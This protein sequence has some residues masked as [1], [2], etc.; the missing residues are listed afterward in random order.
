MKL[1]FYLIDV[2]YEV[3]N[4]APVIMLWGLSEDSEPIL[5]RDTTFRP[6]FYAV[7]RDGADLEE[8]RRGVKALSKPRSPITDVSV[9]DRK[10]YGRPV[11]ALKIVTVVPESVREYRE[12]VSRLPDVREVLEAD[13]RFSMRY[14]LDREA[15]PC[16]WYEAEVEE[17]GAGGL[18]VKGAYTLKSGLQRLEEARPPKLKTLAFDIEVYSPLGSLRPENNPVIIIATANSEGEVRVMV[19]EEGGSD[20]SLIE[21]FV[22]YVIDY[23]PD[24]VVGYNSNMFDWQYLIQRAQALKVRLDVGRVKGGVPRQSAYGHISIP[25]RLH[26]DLYNFAE[27]IPEVKVKSLDEVADYLGVM[28][29]SERVLIPWHEIPRY[30][31]SKELRDTLIRYARDDA[32]ST[33]LLAKEFLPFAIQLSS[34]TGLPLDQV[35]AASVGYRLEWYLMR[36][37]VKYGEL[38]PN[39]VERPYEPYKG[40]IVLEP[41]KGVHEDVVVLDFTSMYPN[42]MI[43]YNVSPDT[44][45][46]GGCDE[47]R[48]HTIEEL[49]Y[50]FLKEPPGFYK[51]VLTTLLRLR[52]EIRTTMKRLDPESLEYRVLDERQRVL[53]ILANASYGYM[54]WVG[55]RW[56]FKEG[57]ESITALGRKT[58]LR[59]IEIARSLGL[60]V[61]YGDTD[62]LFTSYVRDL[63]EDFINRVGDEL[64]LEIKVDKIYRRVFFTEAKKRY[65]GLTEDGRI[66]IVGFEAVRGD[67]TDIAKDVQEEVARIVLTTKNVGEAVNHVRRV[68]EEVRNGRVG[69]EK[70]IIWKTLTKRVSEYEVDAPHVMAARRL[71]KLGIRTDV[72]SKIGYV[73]VRG[74]GNI[75]SRAYP[76]MLVKPNEIDVDYYINHQVIPAA[77]R[78]LSY[79]GVTEKQLEAPRGRSLA[80]FLSKK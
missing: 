34:L 9:A 13:I 52:S 7:P 10:Y 33:L 69:I 58:I 75:S 31:D 67:W 30:W 2:S 20:A 62:S 39:R 79:F 72:G 14:V 5:I 15:L 56:Y 23:D 49:N 18:R 41:V 46:E 22:E 11:K 36:E 44:L 73:V 16:S 74:S 29:K 78:I 28:R 51:N 47:T 42:L 61:I 68:I 37:A 8:V 21:E 55:A 57:A 27:E 64:G 6:Y 60:K 35:G 65:V 66:D 70:L 76:Y 26:V 71:E 54:G 4:N 17:A 63:V 80:D 25:G 3:E 59:A 48:C 77:L 12:E 40:A 38:I 24:V 43:K 50:R 1:K 19:K 32:V 53:K 45:V